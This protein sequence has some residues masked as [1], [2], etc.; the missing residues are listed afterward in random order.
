M[1]GPARA[2]GGGAG[3]PARVPPGGGVGGHRARA[4]GGRRQRAP[5]L[6]RRVA[7][8]RPRR[9]HRVRLRLRR[10]GLLLRLRRLGGG[11]PGILASSAATGRRQRWGGPR[12]ED[13]PAEERAGDGAHLVHQPRGGRRPRRRYFRL[14]RV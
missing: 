8:L 1:A 13:V 9:V 6:L 11:R 7:A 3:V 14:R 4:G 10:L 12:R 5:F 2:G